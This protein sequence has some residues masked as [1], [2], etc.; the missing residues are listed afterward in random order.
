MNKNPHR[1]DDMLH[2]PHHQS[3]SRPHMSNHDRAAQFSPF[4]ALTGYDDQVK[5]T[6]RL[7]DEK[8]E[9]DENE[10][11]ALDEKLQMILEHLREKNVVT[12]TYFLPDSRKDGGAYLTAS[13]IVKTI[14]PYSRSVILYA[15]NGISGGKEIRIDDITAIDGELFQRLGRFT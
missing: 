12:F 1:Y 9:L 14:D 8:I 6:A 3:A 7:T 13:G 11:N 10:K 2:L 5:E 4:A 15:P